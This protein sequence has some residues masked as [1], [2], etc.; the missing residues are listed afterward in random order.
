MKVASLYTYSA[1]SYIR[2]NHTHL[3]LETCKKWPI[4]ILYA[5]VRV[6]VSNPVMAGLH[7][8]IMKLILLLL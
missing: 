2:C 3:L 4:I 1:A 6:Y 7:S 5:G 8:N